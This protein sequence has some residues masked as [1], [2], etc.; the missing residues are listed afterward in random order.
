[1]APPAAVVPSGPP[2]VLALGLTT[3]AVIALDS[4]RPLTSKVAFAFMLSAAGKVRF[5]L[6]R[7]IHARHGT[8]WSPVGPA[9]TASAASGHNTASLSG[10]R[11]LAP[12][13]YRL[14][15]T[16]LSGRAHSIPS[17]S[18]EGS[19]ARPSGPGAIPGGA[20]SQPPCWP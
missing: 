15:V 11:K 13:L 2:V 20:G 14:T 8:H 5:S 9:A 1:M 17:T 19:G 18:T 16:P 7:R 12:G 4:H 6:A 3:R 10:H